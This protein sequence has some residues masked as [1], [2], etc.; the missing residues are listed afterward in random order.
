MP[1]KGRVTETVSD[2][3]Q[4]RFATSGQSGRPSDPYDL[5]SRISTRRFLLLNH[6][7]FIENSSRITSQGLKVYECIGRSNS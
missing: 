4:Q 6:Q 7:K 5:P 1:G 3:L 2:A